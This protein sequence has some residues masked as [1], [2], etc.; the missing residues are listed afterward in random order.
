MLNQEKLNIEEYSSYNISK[1]WNILNYSNDIS[2][3]HTA[4][5]F[6]SNL[7]EKCQNYLKI[8][9]ELYQNSNSSQDKLISSILIYQYIKENYNKFI[10]D[11]ILF[12]NTK[13]FLINEA[14]ISYI[15]NNELDIFSNSEESLII[16][17]ICFALSILLII[18]CFTYWTQG[19]EDLLL[20]SKQSIKHTYLTTII[21]GNCNEELNDIF[22]KKSQEN[23]IKEKFVR[24]K[25]NLKLFINSIL[26]SPNINK[27]LYNKT[28]L[29][30]KNLV[31]FEVNILHIPKM[32]KILLENTNKSN[33]DSFAKLI[34]K[35]IEY[36]KCKKL[37]DDLCGLDLS[38]YD[39]K[40]N[41]DE[42]SNLNLIIEYIY[43]YINNNN[44]NDNNKDN[45]EMSFELGKIISDI[46]ENYVYL[47]FKKDETSQKLLKLFF[48]FVCNK[49]RIISQLFFESILIMKNFI[50]A[51]YKFSNYSKEEKVEF[52]NFLL[53]ICQNIITN[54]T[55]KKIENQEILLKDENIHIKHNNNDKNSDINNKEDKEDLLLGEEI[56]EIPIFEY[57]ANAEDTFFNIFLIFATNFLSEGINYYFETITYPIIPLLSKNISD[58]SISQ[59]LSL[60]SILYSIKSIINSFETLVADKSPLIQFIFL[61]MKSNIV[62]HDF[63][64]S[65]FLLLLEEASTF[66]DYNKKIYEEIITFLLENIDSKIYEK[67]NEALIQLS[68]AVL[69]SILESCGNFYDINIWEKMYFI[70]KNYYNIFTEVSLYNMTESICSF[71]IIENENNEEIQNIKILNNFKKIIEIPLINIKNIRDIIINKKNRNNPGEKDDELLKKEIKKNFNVLTRILKQTSFP[72]DKT[73]INSIFNLL[74]STS[75][76]FIYEIIQ[77]YISFPEIILPFLKL[78][79]KTLLYLNYPTI[80]NI[81][82]NLNQFLLEIFM[83]NNENYQ[84][85]YALKN[86]YMIKL[87]DINDKNIMNEEY[88]LILDNFMKLNRQI[89]YC[90]INRIC[91]QYQLELIQGLSMLFNYVFPLINEIRKDD[92]VIICDTIIIFIEGIKTVCENNIIKNILI[93]FSCF[94]KSNKDD[95]IKLKFNDIILACFYS[96]D[97]YNNMVIN[98]FINFCFDCLNY[99]KTCFLNIL[100]QILFSDDFKFLEDKYKKV[101]FEYFDLYSHDL[102][103]LKSIIIDLMNISKKITAPEILEEYNYELKNINN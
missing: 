26:L 16:E 6:F 54:C 90:I 102:N 75:F 79:T 44:V 56:D 77:E 51:C 100:N 62:K 95:L 8:S 72:K 32:I 9:I 30:S 33:I 12:N 37:E 63:I 85:I 39:N 47:L 69:L 99:N 23:E 13:N 35:C 29:L 74:Y 81:F 38:E 55:Y 7:K 60:E 80:N 49:S 101:V 58:I 19:V 83:K 10:E 25:E 24:N 87:K 89:C 11:E 31:I 66:F 65:N 97:H 27:K 4:N 15:N 86:L 53:K 59:I 78:L 34:S 82:I 2:Q 46:I 70:Y 73:I 43:I 57:R 50:N 5:N 94:I 17:R 41:K 36:S 18:G 1:F 28:I 14:L 52:S 98:S 42:L 67:N 61:L 45:K 40:M 68:T 48:F 96:L 71:L 92:Y 103:K 76:S 91:P 88:I 22:L 84:S 21:L 3:K 93:S 20:F 64:Y